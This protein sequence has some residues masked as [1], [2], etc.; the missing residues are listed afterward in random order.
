M[1]N[2]KED[3][4]QKYFEWSSRPAPSFDVSHLLVPER[5]TDDNDDGI[6]IKNDTENENASRSINELENNEIIS[7]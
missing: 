3:L 5:R 7:L 1:P 6:R 2:K 4:I